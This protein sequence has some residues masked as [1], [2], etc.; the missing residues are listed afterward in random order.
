[1]KAEVKEVKEIKKEKSRQLTNPIVTPQV[2]LQNSRKARVKYLVV[3]AKI[4]LLNLMLALREI[5]DGEYYLDLGYSSFEEFIASEMPLSVS[6]S[7]RLLLVTDAFGADEEIEKL[8]G[9][10]KLKE[11]ANI[12]HDSGLSYSG[13]KVVTESGEEHLLE[14]YL[15]DIRAQAQNER[16][17]AVK[18]VEK[19]LQKSNKR[20]TEMRDQSA[21]LERSY[22]EEI[23]LLKQKLDAIAKRASLDPQR[24]YIVSGKKEALMLI[25]EKFGQVSQ[26]LGAL[27]NIPQKFRDPEIAAALAQVIIAIESGI[28]ALREDWASLLFLPLSEEGE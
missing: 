4:S 5:R 21:E 20:L 27:S 12:A 25:Q 3:T 15:T 26:L 18:Q 28:K 13:G 19:D 24:L 14:D 10:G 9:D 1:M 22:Q 2:E 7:R 17:R 6:E 11:L 8:I 23:N 16:K